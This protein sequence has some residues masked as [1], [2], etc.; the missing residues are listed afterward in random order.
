MKI[1]KPWTPNEVT[2]LIAEYSKGI[3]QQRISRAL[4]R[5][6]GSVHNKITELIASGNIHQAIGK[7]NYTDALPEKFILQ[8]E[9]KHTDFLKIHGNT[10]NI[11]DVHIPFWHRDL[12][13]KVIKVAKK[14]KIQNLIINGDFLN[15]DS[16]SRWVSGFSGQTDTL[17]EL[18]TANYF[19][20]QALKTFKKIYLTSGNHEDRLF[21]TLKGQIPQS[22]FLRM[23]N[24]E[25]G[26]RIIVSDYAYCHVNDIWLIGH[27]SS[28]S[29]RGGQTPSEIADVTDMNVIL[30]HN[31]QFGIQTS[32]NGKHVGIDHGCSCDP[33][34]IEYYSKGV[35]KGRRWQPGF[36]MIYNNKGYAFSYNFSDWKFW[37]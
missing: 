32:R 13:D 21:K 36:S 3:K 29:D 12:F 18:D 20:I 1:N 34:Q 26:K 10:I 35:T 9:K 24:D 2:F 5:S 6:L 28:F 22:Y 7:S 14:F 37:L 31:H 4:G 19:L 25:I 23:I 15:M 8:D 27:P 16:F 17:R 30:G 11:S 33:I